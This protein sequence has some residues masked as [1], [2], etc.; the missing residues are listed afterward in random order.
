MRSALNRQ[1]MA[2]RDE[3][4]ALTERRRAIARASG[5]RDDE[6]PLLL[7]NLAAPLALAK[8]RLEAVERRGA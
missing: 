3:V 2:L 7:T 1:P 5:A 4:A 8:K 6:E